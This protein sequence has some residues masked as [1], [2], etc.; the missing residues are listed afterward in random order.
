M[1]ILSIYSQIDMSKIG[2]KN[3]LK[4]KKNNNILNQ[5]S[6]SYGKDEMNNFIINSNL[7]NNNSIK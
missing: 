6:N 5:F 7:E 3:P 2:S 1:I 4:D